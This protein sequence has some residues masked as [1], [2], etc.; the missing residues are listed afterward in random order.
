MSVEPNFPH[1]EHMKWRYLDSLDSLRYS[2]KE[3]IDR[4][5]SRILRVEQASAE[6]IATILMGNGI[7]IPN[8]QLMDSVGFL[9]IA[10]DIIRGAA[11]YIGEGKNVFMPLRYANYDYSHEPAGGRHLRNPFLLTSYLFA[12]DGKDGRNFFE[13]SAWNRM[14]FL[15]KEVAVVLADQGP[16]IPSKYLFDPAEAQLAEDLIRVLNFF[17]MNPHLISEA[18]GIKNVR[19]EM[20]LLIAALSKEKVEQDSYFTHVLGETSSGAFT[21]K[22]SRLWDIIKVIRNTT[23]DGSF[24]YRGTIREKLDD[25][26]SKYFDGILGEPSSVRDG[27]LIT[28]NSIYNFSGYLSTRA[29]QENQ[30]EMMK[31]D[32]AWGYDEA[33]FAL[34]QWARINYEKT[35]LDVTA[36]NDIS[37]NQDSLMPTDIVV[38]ADD[39]SELWNNFFDYQ[40]S[41]TWDTSLNYYINSLIVLESKKKAEK[42]IFK[43]EE[44]HDAR[45]RYE[46]RRNKH[47]SVINEF[48]ATNYKYRN[49]KI[50]LEAN[51]AVLVCSDLQGNLIS[52]IQIEDFGENVMLTKEEKIAYYAAEPAINAT[53]KG[54][55]ADYRE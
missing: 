44:L 13:L 47:I 5:E 37:S 25:L 53:S 52:K 14:A 36:T 1:R 7:V 48:L 33:A 28:V 8:N 38:P 43:T 20:I 55:I 26:N 46:D 30:T 39:A 21:E 24:D 23:I 51:K 45:E 4:G 42:S 18:A 31:I 32:G 10:S 11:K 34:G 22:L 41:G 49:Y 50:E 19:E 29:K 15:R 2:P 9:R 17:A 35:H 6:V 16:A 3:L 12:K 27:V 54:S 40:R